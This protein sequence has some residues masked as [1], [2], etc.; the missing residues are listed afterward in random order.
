[1]YTIGAFRVNLGPAYSRLR[2]RVRGFQLALSG[3]L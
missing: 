1:M 3:S 2:F